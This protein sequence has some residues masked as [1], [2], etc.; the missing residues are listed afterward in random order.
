LLL[1]ATDRE[2]RDRRRLLA[3]LSLSETVSWGVLY[4]A[5]TV[6]VRPMEAELGWSRLATSAAFSIGLLVSAVAAPLAGRIV[7]A[8]RAR[9]LMTAGSCLGTLMLLAWSRVTTLGGLYLVWVG[10]GLAMAATLYE[11]AF[12][13]LAKRFGRDRPRA[14]TTLTL[15][16]G[17][18][19][20]IFLPVAGHLE[21]RYGWRA[22]LAILAVVVAGVAAPAHAFVLGPDGRS[23][24]HPRD[25]GAARPRAA[26]TLGVE[27]PPAWRANPAFWRLAAA[28]ALG[29]LT[30]GTLGAHLVPYLTGRGETA[31]AA[32]ALA[33]AV[34]AMQLP[35]RL[36][37]AR[38]SSLVPARPILAATFLLQ[39]LGLALMLVAPGR[40]GAVAFVLCFGVG[41]GAVTLTR[42]TVVAEVFGTAA[43]GQTAGTLAAFTIAARALGPLTAG[44]AYDTTGRYEPLLAAL[45][46]GLGLAALAAPGFPLR[47]P[48]AVDDR[49]GLA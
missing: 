10:M 15:V 38:V 28:F 22:A 2:A 5:F 43:Y 21:Q 25:G 46:A 34:G 24:G 6:F 33:G 1:R 16:A 37:F 14:L 27:E 8:G 49:P 7:D 30:A 4:Y 40:A 48:E 26:S 44:W 20:T 42:A 3:G 31:P 17:L 45:A 47:L 41:N 32:A 36:V 39:A 12:A 29:G 18:A 13:V 23:D 11:P 9:I 35:G 19:S